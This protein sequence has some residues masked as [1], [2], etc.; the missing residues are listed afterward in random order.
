MRSSLLILAAGLALT[1][2][3]ALTACGA[4]NDLAGAD[5][6]TGTGGT[7]GTSGTGGGGGGALPQELAQLSNT[8]APNDGPAI[9]LMVDGLAG[10]PLVPQP[11]AGFEF[12]VWAP[13]TAKLH[14][15]GVVTLG[16]DFKSGASALRWNVINGAVSNTPVTDGSLFIDTFVMGASATGTFNMILS[17]GSTA[18]GGFSA[19]W[20]QNT[21]GCGG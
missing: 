18:Q 12:T 4:R 2:L 9:G 16:G 8:C 10:C 7:T 13:A 6:S 20:C 1:A 17:D 3:T 14:A 11:V 15:G 19:V 5:G 21:V